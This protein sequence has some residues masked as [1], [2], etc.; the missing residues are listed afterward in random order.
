[1]LIA[2]VVVVL[3]VAVVAAAARRDRPLDEK[4]DDLLA[5][6]AETFG[7]EPEG[8]GYQGSVV[9]RV[10]A[11]H[12]ER[13]DAFAEHSAVYAR[14]SSD[15]PPLSQVT[16]RIEID[17]IPPDFALG[18]SAPLLANRRQVGDKEFERRYAVRDEPDD[19]VG[20]LDERRRRALVDSGRLVWISDGML[21]VRLGRLDPDAPA[22]SLQ[23]AIDFA[24]SLEGS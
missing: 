16:A 12:R 1:M 17:G 6:V 13:S 21:I 24:A 9:G 2:L 19:V 10:V 3:A 11:L 22:Q 15:N 5:Q 7:L 23:A 8:K 4:F 18:Q 14:S 20:W